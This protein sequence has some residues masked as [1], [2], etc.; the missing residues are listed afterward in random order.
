M[1][2]RAGIL[3]TGT[4]V[5]TGRVTDRNG[6]WLAERLRQLGVDVGR[7]VVVGDRPDD[8]RTA[9][10][11]LDDLDLVVTSGGLGPTADD[12][13]LEIVAAHRGRALHHDAEL[14]ERIAERVEAMRRRRGWAVDADALRA[15]NRKQA[16]VP[17][18]A[19]L[20]EPVGTAP[21]VVVPGPPPVVVLPGPPSELQQ[22]WA[23]AE[24]S[25]L[26]QEVLAR[27]GTLEQR[28][29][30]LWGPPEAALADALRRAGDL[31]GVELTTCVRT[32]EL[33][34]VG[35]FAPAAADVWD[36]L[37][38]HLQEEFGP[39]LFSP[40]GRSVD[41][42]VADLA[43]GTGATVATA[44]SC[45]GGLLGAR[46]TEQPGSSGWVVGGVV[47]YADRVKIEQ[48]GV[49]PGLLERHGAVSEPVARA[50][51]E[52]VRDRLRSTVGVGITGVAGPGGGTET[53]PVGLV[54]LAVAGPGTTLHRELR[55]GGARTD[56]RTYAVQHA[57]HLLREALD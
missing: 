54:H 12:L 13:T 42:V 55:A 6:P 30:R 18:G 39:A 7:V 11:Q 4:E 45:T 44:E 8:L 29:L 27:A 21:G 22:M 2:V 57:L 25:P 36:G 43:V 1:D 5:L 40:D 9:L 28:T 41:E 34:V 50:M 47:A 35:R 53:K 14:E 15:A 49:P 19:S 10:T 16:L 26:V 20:L 17:A 37:G 24:A 48:L 56:I 31:S 33:E 3:V 46:L 52:G 32:A 38:A 23:A 51:A